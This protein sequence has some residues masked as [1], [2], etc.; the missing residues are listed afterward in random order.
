M[1]VH[2]MCML[3]ACTAEANGSVLNLREKGEAEGEGGLR[4]RQS[5]YGHGMLS[6]ALRACVYDVAQQ[7]S[8]YVTL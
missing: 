3:G 4:P 2:L 6:S 1:Q 7:A 8:M 5:R